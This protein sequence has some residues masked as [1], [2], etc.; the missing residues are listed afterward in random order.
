ML[1]A[2]RSFLSFIHPR[3]TF[4]FRIISTGGWRQQGF[5]GERVGLV[6]HKYA[7]HDDDSATPTG[8]V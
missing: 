1:F 5:H 8:Y 4:F 2:E 7:R 3:N 6:L